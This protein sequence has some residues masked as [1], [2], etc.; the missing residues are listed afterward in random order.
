MSQSVSLTRRRDD[1][2]QGR[3]REVQD[4]Y[5][6]GIYLKM[7]SHKLRK[8]VLRH[9]CMYVHVWMSG[10]EIYARANEWNVLVFA[11]GG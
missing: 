3:N 7:H 4:D 9:I 5:Y 8:V 2:K 11:P 10:F 6:G 1:G